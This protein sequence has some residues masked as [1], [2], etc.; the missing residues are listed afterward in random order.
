MLSKVEHEEYLP[1][2]QN[3]GISPGGRA[4]VEGCFCL[5]SASPPGIAIK[6]S[7]GLELPRSVAL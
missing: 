1:S 5:P 6:T 3:M 7:Y 2:L 4:A